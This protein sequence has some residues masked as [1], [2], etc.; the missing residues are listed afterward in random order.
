MPA[1]RMG[2]EATTGV[3]AHLIEEAA[4]LY[5]KGP[6]L[7]WMGQGFQRQTFGGNAMRAVGLLP[8][9]TGNIG[10]YGAGFL[11]LNGWDTRGV[12]A[13]YLAASHLNQAPAPSI[14][15]MD[16]ASRLEQ[17]ETQ[18]L[19]TWNNNIA[20]SSPEQQPPAARARARGPF[21]GHAR[22]VPDRH[23]RLRRLRAAGREL[24]RVRRRRHVVLQ[25]LDL[26]PGEGGAAARRGAAQ[27]G[28]LPAPR[29]RHAARR[30]RALRTRRE[31]HRQHLLAQAKPG[32]DVRTLAKLGTVA[33]PDRSP[34][35]SSSATTT[36]RPRARSS[37]PGGRV[38]RCRSAERALR[39]RPR[40]APCGASCASCRRPPNG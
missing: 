4:L 6:S 16:L 40:P 8:A 26:G 11:Y 21:P 1:R 7:L 13:G 15:H 30:A 10:K 19:I 2:R 20:V 28:D 33:H 12:D 39:F 32:L 3:P 37:S 29:T 23:R 9:A 22:P 25:L 17:P 31:P 18:A 27:P 5:A 34:S 38:R 35:C 24:P 36:A 14:S